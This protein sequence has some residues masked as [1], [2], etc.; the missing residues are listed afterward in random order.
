MYF[1][2]CT[3]R[4]PLLSQRAP[5][6]Q[7]SPLSCT[8][9]S[10]KSVDRCPGCTQH[11]DFSTPDSL[12]GR[13]KRNEECSLHRRQAGTKCGTHTTSTLSSGKPLIYF[14]TFFCAFPCFSVKKQ[15][16]SNPLYFFC[17]CQTAKKKYKKSRL[18]NVQKWTKEMPQN[19]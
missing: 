5:G 16:K 2:P 14:S 10:H 17:T 1:H 12:D 19:G 15:K 7:C 13:C 9:A 3:L 8:S 18:P 4:L 6:V 11:A